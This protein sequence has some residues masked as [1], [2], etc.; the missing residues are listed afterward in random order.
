MVE[1]PTASPQ[2]TPLPTRSD[3]IAET[4]AARDLVAAVLPIHYPRALLYAFGIRRSDLDAH[5]D[6]ISADAAEKAADRSNV[7]VEAL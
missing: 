3:V 7:V 2:W 1:P 6:I 4:R 5:G